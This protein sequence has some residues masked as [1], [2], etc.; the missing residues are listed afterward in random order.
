FHPY[1]NENSL[2]LGDW[3]WNQGTLKS[4][5]SFK[6]LLNIVGSSEF[7]PEDVCNTKWA[8]IDC[9]LGNNDPSFV[10]LA[11]WLDDDAGWKRTTITI[12]VPFPRCSV[13]PGP[14]NY[15]VTDFYCCSLVSVI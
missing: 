14:K 2:R 11:E 1:P 15:T 4:R 8:A 5:S 3:F 12:S 10:D 7:R 6:Q 9:E 13:H